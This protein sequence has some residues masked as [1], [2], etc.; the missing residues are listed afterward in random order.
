M[1]QTQTMTEPAP[2]NQSKKPFLFSLSAKNETA[3]SKWISSTWKCWGAWVVSDDFMPWTMISRTYSDAIRRCMSLSINTCAAAFSIWN[4][5]TKWI[6][7]RSYF[8][9]RL[10]HW[11]YGKQI[12]DS[13]RPFF[14]L[15]TL[16]LITS[17][18]T[19]ILTPQKSNNWR[20]AP[21]SSPSWLWASSILRTT[22]KRSTVLYSPPFPLYSP[23]SYH[24]LEWLNRT[25]LQ[26]MPKIV[27]ATFRRKRYWSQ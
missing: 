16:S 27:W 7:G 26:S 15:R 9:R 12:I 5:K 14:C 1:S 23:S 18:P 21:I 10:C 3:F 2:Q 22:H 17:I 20:L 19:I 4:S 13:P 6:L 8:R 24:P 25:M 11:H